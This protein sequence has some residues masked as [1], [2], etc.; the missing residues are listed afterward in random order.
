LQRG[1]LGD[2]TVISRDSGQVTRFF[3]A[4]RM[5]TGSFIEFNQAPDHDFSTSFSRVASGRENNP[6]Q[7]EIGE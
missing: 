6:T 5:R 4:D 7:A 2:A 3:F 1:K